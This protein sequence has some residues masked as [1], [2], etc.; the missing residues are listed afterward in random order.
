M[1]FALQRCD[2]AREAVLLIGDLMIRYGF[3]PSSGDGS[4]TLVIADTDEAWVLEVF[5]VGNGWEP[6]YRQ[7]RGHLGSTAAS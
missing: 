7:A 6:G 5:G 2:K 4:E 3:L 1:I